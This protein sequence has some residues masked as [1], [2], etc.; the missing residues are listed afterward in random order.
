[1]VL[2][3]LSYCRITESNQLYCMTSF[4]S[5]TEG[6]YL[7]LCSGICTSCSLT[8][9]CSHW[10][11]GCSTLKPI[12]C[13][14][15]AR[16][17]SRTKWHRLRQL[18]SD[19]EP[20]TEHTDLSQCRSSFCRSVIRTLNSFPEKDVVVLRCDCISFGRSYFLPALLFVD[21]QNKHDFHEKSTFF[22]PSFLCEETV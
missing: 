18:Q 1:M 8:M 13:P 21:N 20:G 5:Y 15:S 10:R 19:T 16:A 9:T 3:E 12:R 6:T 7:S 2:K 22:F 17:A 11:T 4:I 14:S